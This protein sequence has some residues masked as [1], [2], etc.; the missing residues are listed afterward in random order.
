MQRPNFYIGIDVAS[1][2]FTATILREP[3]KPSHSTSVA[4]SME[5]FSSF[6]QWLTERN[7]TLSNAI[8]CLEAT[9][10]YGEALCYFLTSHGYHIV[11]E[12]PLKV[13]RAFDITGHKTDAV[14]SAQ[15]AEYA[16]RFFDELNVWKPNDAIIEH[17]K[18]LL[19]TREQFSR[20][21]VANITTLKTLERKYIQTPLANQAYQE[22][23]EHLKEQISDID[24]EIKRFIDQDP[25][26]RQRVALMT[27]IPGVGFLLASNLLVLTRGFTKILTAKQ[28]AAHAGI[29]PYQHT[30]G[31]SVYKRPR[32]RRHGPSMLRKL[33]YLAALSLRTHN[34]QFR[35][36]FHRKVAEGK[37]KRLVINNIENK[38]LKIICAIIASRTQ[39]IPNYQSVNPI[40]LKSA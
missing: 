24:Q 16:H 31:I 29:C 13:K 28:L 17:I 5:G 11:V 18:V 38:L 33:L 6:L 10:V 23:I 37:S 7:V 15:I 14:D 21:L 3:G 32:S 9:G 1:T 30:S 40:L 4:N 19:A 2:T 20:Q 27:S 22:T 39:F 35:R 8:V 26:F 36:Y 25:T 12:P 34:E